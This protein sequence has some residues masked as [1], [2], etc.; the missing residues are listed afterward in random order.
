[1]KVIWFD[2]WQVW[3]HKRTSQLKHENNAASRRKGFLPHEE[4]EERR[5][6]IVI[7]RSMLQHVISGGHQQ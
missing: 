6:T 3:I 7:N 2:L 5:K 1:M 4:K